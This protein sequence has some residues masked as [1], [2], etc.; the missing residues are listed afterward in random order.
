M[1]SKTSEKFELRFL[2]FG[3]SVIKLFGQKPSLPTPVI[4]QVI[5]SATSIGANYAEAQ[6]AVSRRDFINKIGISKKEAAETRYWLQM[7]YSLNN[8]ETVLTC[9][10]E[11]QEILMILQKTVN[12]LRNAK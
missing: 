11:S 2:E 6:S 4:N 7:I 8:D 5:R 3:V 1:Q 12:T 9:L 10:K